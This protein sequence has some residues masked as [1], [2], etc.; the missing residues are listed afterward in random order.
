MVRFSGKAMAVRGLTNYHLVAVYDWHI[1]QTDL[2]TSTSFLGETVGPGCNQTALRRR[3]YI[4]FH[5]DDSNRGG[6]ET[7]SI[8]FLTALSH[9]KW[10]VKTNI[11]LRGDWYDEYSLNKAEGPIELRAYLRHDVTNEK[12]AGSDIHYKVRPGEHG[13]HCPRTKMAYIAI[14]KVSWGMTIEFLRADGTEDETFGISPATTSPPV[15]STA[16]GSPVATI[17][18]LPK[19]VWV[20]GLNDKEL[21]LEYTWTARKMDLDTS[22]TFMEETVGYECVSKSSRYYSYV[23]FAGDS[24]EGGKEEA[25][26]DIFRSRRDGLWGGSCKIRARAHWY[27][28]VDHGNIMIT[29]YLRFETTGHVV[30]GT[31]MTLH[32]HPGLYVTD[33][34]THIVAEVEILERS[35]GFVLKLSHASGVESSGFDSG[36]VP[37]SRSELLYY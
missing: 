13:L 3:Q 21:V 33:C 22:T 12:L 37:A 9:G 25:R 5:G 29:A 6:Q 10:R 15:V 19:S 34:A 1:D 27:D 2:D 35:D 23:H 17:P 16:S 7:V 32:V 8:H 18:S 14:R 31:T 24:R 30:S 20:A 28:S 11:T 4:T 26:I 36:V